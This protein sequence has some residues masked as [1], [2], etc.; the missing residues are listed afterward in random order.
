MFGNTI[1]T[2][3]TRLLVPLLISWPLSNSN[4]KSL[5]YTFTVRTFCS[6]PYLL[7]MVLRLPTTIYNLGLLIPLCSIFVLLCQTR[8]GNFSEMRLSSLLFTIC[9][10]GLSVYGSIAGVQPGRIVQR[11]TSHTSPDGPTQT[12]TIAT[13]N[14]WYDVVE[15]DSCL[16]TWPMTVYHS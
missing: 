10:F 11:V 12:G 6:I 16:S 15:N 5:H 9:I 13:C 2:M 3:E 1:F 7:W 8:C 4:F 14:L